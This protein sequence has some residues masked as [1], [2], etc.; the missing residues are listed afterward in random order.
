MFT[1]IA[2]VVGAVVIIVCVLLVRRI[3]RNKG[4][5]VAPRVF[6][7]R[8]VSRR[9]AVCGGSVNVLVGRRSYVVMG[10][11]SN[12][13][14]QVKSTI[15]IGKFCSL[16]SVTFLLNGDSGHNHDILCSTYQWNTVKRGEGRRSHVS[17]GNDVWIGEN[18]TILGGVIVGDGAIIGANALVSKDVPPYTIVG[19]NPAKEIRQRY[20]PEQIAKLLRIQWWHI[21][22][23]PLLLRR[24]RGKSIDEQI[25][26]M[27]AYKTTLLQKTSL[28]PERRFPS[29]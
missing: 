13:D 24:C 2:F 20:T 9:Y 16:N 3:M 17:I 14:P 4:L 1:R 15:T 29:P 25:A 7:R 26:T 22:H 28:A 12:Y 10:W 18:V 19:G 8:H 23:I 6:G 11:V 27:E 21:K 5:F